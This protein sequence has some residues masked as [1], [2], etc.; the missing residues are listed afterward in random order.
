MLLEP[1][2]GYGVDHPWLQTDGHDVSFTAGPEALCL[3]SGVEVETA[4]WRATAAFTVLKGDRVP[5]VLSWHPSHQRP[6]APLDA[7]NAEAQTE[8]WWRQWS[9]RCTYRG[10][11]RDAVMR[12]LIVLKALTYAPTGGIVAAPT[13]SLPEEIGGVRNWDYRF[14]WIRDAALTLIALMIGG[15]TDE[16]LAWR[17]WLFR[18]AAGAPEQ[19]Q[20]MY[21]IAGE[22]RLTEMTL[23]WLPGYEG[24]RPVRVGNGAASQFQLD[25]YGEL[26][27]CLYLSRRM[28]IGPA[29]SWQPGK[30][31]LEFLGKAWQRPDEGIWEVRGGGLRHFTY[32]KVM[33]WVAFDRAIRLIEEFG[34]GGKEASEL[35]PHLRTLRGRV[36]EEVCQRGFNERVGAFT[37]SYGIESLDASV[38]LIPHVEFLPASDPRLQSTVR[39]IEKGLMMDG[40]VRRYPTEHNLDGLPGSEGAFLACSFWLADNYVFAN[41]MEEAEE[42]FARLLGIRNHLGLLAEEYDPMARRQLGNFPQAFSHL[43]LVHT[44]LLLEG[45][46]KS[47]STPDQV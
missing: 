22:R 21:G 9:A 46:Y 14:C 41:R 19:L 39:A 10:R 36:H 17:N 44:A 29:E 5:F 23:D 6:P 20:I 28:G 16:A 18:T 31:L 11:H 37:Q 42:M 40:F 3:R 43:A 30:M 13:T 8:T 4:S 7:H 32:S 27:S 26:F 35:L 1:R 15:Y 45:S 34:T 2:F 25:V 24:S 12:S 47:G 33:V 38:L